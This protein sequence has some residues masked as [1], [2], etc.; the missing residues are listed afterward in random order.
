MG[1]EAV[2]ITVQCKATGLEM[3][4]GDRL[5]LFEFGHSHRLSV[6]FCCGISYSEQAIAG[7]VS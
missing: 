4:F 6:K 5:T 1:K 7:R 2:V 3:Y